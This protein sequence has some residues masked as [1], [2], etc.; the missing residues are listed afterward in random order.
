MKT[1]KHLARI[2]IVEDENIIAEDMKTTLKCYGYEI[3]AIADSGEKAIIE[4]ENRNPDLILMDIMLNG[5]LDGIETADRIKKKLG[6]QVIYLTAYSSDSTIMKASKTE[7]LG[8]LLKPFDERELHATI[9]MALYK[10]R[11]KN[12]SS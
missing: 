7:P 9:Q 5:E 2:M 4:A 8:Y 10:I 12:N 3:V 6:I 1:N 11:K